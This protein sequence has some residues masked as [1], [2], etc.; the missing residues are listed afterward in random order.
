MNRHPHRPLLA[1]VALAVALP[2]AA[3]DLTVVS[4]VSVGKGKESTSTQ[5]ITAEKV[6]TSDGQNDTVLDYASG[7]MVMIDHKEKSYF[8]TS[9]AEMSAKLEELE[10]QMK[11]N[12]MLE[13]M[14]GQIGEVTVT[15]LDGKKAIAG[16]ETQQY[17]L[18]MGDSMAF[19]LW[20]AP[21]LAAPHQY[22]DARKAQYV[23]MGPMGKRFARMFEEMKKIEGFP[24]ATSMSMKMMGVKQETTTEATEVKKGAIPAA[25]F[26]VP[27]GYKKKDSPFQGEK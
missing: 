14:F 11:G 5:Y 21:G 15:K 18:T 8:E 20:A 27:S 3:E 7:K 1:L 9:L 22:F 24:L 2:A 6:R 4:K 16:Y 12:P 13:K 25:A 26:E 10:A 17:Q 23:S 19:D